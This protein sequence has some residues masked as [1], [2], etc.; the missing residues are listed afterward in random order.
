MLLIVRLMFIADWNSRL[1]NQ[2]G[3]PWV[4]TALNSCPERRRLRVAFG[5]FVGRFRE[6]HFMAAK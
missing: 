3:H 6:E 4:G 1:R 5:P 2:C